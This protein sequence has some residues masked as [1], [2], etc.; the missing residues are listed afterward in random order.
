MDKYNNFLTMV[1]VT[2]TGKQ[3]ICYCSCAGNM[4]IRKTITHNELADN[5]Y[6][7]LHMHHVGFELTA[8]PYILLLQVTRWGGVN[9]ARAHWHDELA[10][11]VL[12]IKI[13]RMY[14]YNM[15]KC[16]GEKCRS[17]IVTRLVTRPSW[18]DGS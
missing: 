9:W 8:S 5:F 11:K 6:W 16:R 17:H 12:S 15:M 1:N 2:W 7:K 13:W 14:K 3:G 18:I 10:E 4:T